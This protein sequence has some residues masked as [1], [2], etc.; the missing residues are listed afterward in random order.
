MGT[1]GGE[2]RVLLNAL[3]PMLG[4]IGDIRTPQEVM[5]V[6]GMMKDAEK[7]MSRCVYLNILKATCKQAL[8]SDEKRNTLDKFLMTGGWGIL[9]KWLHEFTKSENF[10][11]LLEL[12]DVLRI[13]PITVELL[14]QGNTGKLIKQMTKLDNADV[15]KNAGSL[16]RQWKDMIRGAPDPK[17]PSK[18]NDVAENGQEVATKR[19]REQDAKGPPE[20]KSKTKLS[21]SFGFMAALNAVPAAPIKK[22][23]RNSD[24]KTTL[25]LDEI[26][27]RSSDKKQK[28]EDERVGGDSALQIDPDSSTSMQ[29]ISPAVEAANQA[30]ASIIDDNPIVDE[31]SLARK[32]NKKKRNITWATDDKLV[33]IEYYVVPDCER[34]RGHNESFSDAKQHEL[35]LEKQAMRSHRHHGEDNM[36]E[37]I[38]WKRLI[39]VDNAGIP[40]FISGEK[41]LEKHIQADREKSVL[42]FIFLTKE[43]LPDNPT[44]AD[45]DADEHSNR[46]QVRMI[47]HDEEGTVIPVSKPVNNN[48]S[49]PSSSSSR[50]SKDKDPSPNKPQTTPNNNSHIPNKKPANPREVV[51][52]PAVHNIMNQ[53]LRN[54]PPGSEPPPQKIP[55][56][57]TNVPSMLLPVKGQNVPPP[58]PIGIRPDNNTNVGPPFNNQGDQDIPSIMDSNINLRGR[59][60][61]GPRFRGG[62]PPNPSRGGFIPRGGPG[63]PPRWEG[64]VPEDW[65]YN[66]YNDG[67]PPFNDNYRPGP[68]SRGGGNF[69][70]PPPHGGRNNGFNENFGNS[71]HRGGF[72]RGGN[73]RNGNDRGR[74]GNNRNR[75][76]NNEWENDNGPPNDRREG[77][78]NRGR[79]RGRGNN[80][81]NN[82]DKGQ[83]RKW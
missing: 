73:N 28:V 31:G 74:G 62:P 12:I 80:H 43:S 20:K 79:G 82:R 3:K 54:N 50:Q 16:I 47:P 60:P 81:R 11:V 42:A 71:N 66:N 70:P 24:P 69:G 48:T 58:P 4:V 13:L 29:Y 39:P 22:K 49:S 32:K 67:G 75:D 78:W 7:L 63:A 46:T 68:N 40:N 26:L 19:A 51:T 8:L 17:K 72:H 61:M 30:L 41:S 56:L 65:N 2:P 9:N 76:W 6:V 1:S 57:G 45:F 10:P 18:E 14:K 55:T 21:D 83:W 37:R 23:R 25:P 59:G 36:I 64:P 34:K 38:R 27:N 35:M 77:D 44:E 33:Q 15:K 52:S 53:L 5:R